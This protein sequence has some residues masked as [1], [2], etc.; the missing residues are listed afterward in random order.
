MEKKLLRKQAGENWT[1]SRKKKEGTTNTL[2]GTSESMADLQIQTS[3]AVSHHPTKGHP[4]LD[5]APEDQTEVVVQR[6]NVHNVQW[7]GQEVSLPSN[8]KINSNKNDF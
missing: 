3:S 5:L 7:Q 2:S 8:F 4:N 6:G 1:K